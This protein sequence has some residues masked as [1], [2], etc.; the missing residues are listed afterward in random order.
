MDVTID[1]AEL[2]AVA[3]RAGTI[4]PAASPI[5]SLT[6]VLLE[7]DKLP[8]KLTVSATNME[9]G[10]EVQLPCSSGDDDA[11]VINTRLLTAML[12]KLSGEFVSLKR[13][14][15]TSQ[16]MVAS[17]QASYLI[18]VWER[19]S[20]PS[21]EIPFP[22]DTVR[23][24]GIPAM[25]KKTVFATS[26]STDKPLLRCVNLMFTKDGLKAAGSNGTC[27]VTAR[28]D[29]KSTGNISLLLPAHSLD[30]LARMSC[31][32]DEF[33]VGTT[34]K[35]LVFF[36]EDFVFSARLMD[37]VYINTEQIV[38]SITNVFTVLTDVQDLRSALYSVTSVEENGRVK[39]LF[40]GHR[41]TFYC[42]G[43][44]GSATKGLDVIPMSGVPRGEYWFLSGELMACLRSLTG[45]VT[46]GIAQGGMLTL[47]TEDAFYMQTAVRAPAASA[48]HPKN[49]KKAA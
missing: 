24:S 29:N 11:V 12:D 34:G 5:A 35:E 42:S 37:G 36:K 13:E 48:E 45:T 20:F 30:K 21:M 25:A 19:A 8:G 22:D 32:Q 10:L 47:S 44:H 16:I 17:G 15:G 33:R 46:L 9:I 39:L 14:K 31:D 38:S 28:G 49:A 18:P 40:D 7:T 27:F 26:Q 23:V 43:A 3:R 2:L 4:A 6:G 1:R 41:L